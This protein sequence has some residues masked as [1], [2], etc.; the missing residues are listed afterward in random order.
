MAWSV[1]GGLLEVP[2]AS[3]S[4]ELWCYADRFDY[5]HGDTVRLKVHTTAE[6]FNVNIVRDGAEPRTVYTRKNLT[7]REQETPWDAYATGCDWEDSLTFSIDSGWEPGFY[8]I[9][10]EAE[11][12]GRRQEHEGFF[13]IRPADP[14]D[15][16]F[17]LVHTTSTML[18]YNDWGG[19]NHY[20][21]LPDGHLNDTPSPFS[22]SQRPIARGMLRKPVGAPRNIH[23]NTPEIGWV[24]RHETYE[25]AW[26]NGYSRHHADAGWATYERPFTVWAEGQGYRVGHTTQ[27][28][29]HL[30]PAALEGYACVVIVGHD[31]YWTWEM[32]D[33]IDSFV[34]DGGHLARFAGNYVWQVRFDEK[35]QTQTCYKMPFADPYID[36]DITKVTTMWDWKPIGRPGAATMGLSGAAGSYIRYGSASPRASGGFTVYRPEHWIFESTDLYYGDV[37][38]AAPICVAAFEVDGVD[39]TFRK[40][41]PYATGEGGAPEN[42]EILAMTPAVFGAEDRWSGTVPIGAPLEEATALLEEAYDGNPPEYQTDTVRGAAMIAAFVRGKGEVLTAGSTEWVNGLIHRDPFTEQITRNVLNRFT[43]AEASGSADVKEPS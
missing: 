15:V 10:L 41:L 12:N 40:G 24:P 33:R 21:G 3:E 35:A 13:I 38:G 2:G 23:T 8:L 20:R 6:K 14:R 26:L 19:G 16:D 17:L 5:G 39:Y 4:I 36:Q 37:F 25:W 11:E 34:D 7:G 22:S 32:R 31:E 1:P 29:L 9:I 43:R 42:L 30:D 28:H 27:S 18:A